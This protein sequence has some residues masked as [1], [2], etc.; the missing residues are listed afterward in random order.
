MEHVLSDAEK[1]EK[2]HEIISG[3][4]TAMLVTRTLD[5]VLRSRPLSIARKKDDD[6]LYFSTG[7]D[8]GKVSELESDAHVNVAM[9]SRTKFASVSGHALLSRERALVDELW[10]EAWRI[11]FP[12]GKDDPTLVIVIVEPEEAAYWDAGGT[13]GLRYFFES[14]K[15]YVKGERPAS[16]DDE[17]HTA[18]LKL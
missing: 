15:A 11:W 17:R 16:D 12:G 10:S 14:A 5:G 4:D 1:R 8:T 7:I 18:R 9:Q 13:T 3:F 2:L 6:R